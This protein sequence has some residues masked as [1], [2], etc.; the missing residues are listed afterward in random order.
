VTNIIVWDVT[1]Y[2]LVEVLTFQRNALLLSSGPKSKSCNQTS[3]EQAKSFVVIC[4]FACCDDFRPR[5][6]RQYILPKHQTSARLHGVTFGSSTFR[7]M[8]LLNLIYTSIVNCNIFF[9]GFE[10]E[11]EI[12]YNYR[13]TANQFVLDPSP[14][15]LTT[16]MFFNWTLAVIILTRGWGCRLQLLLALV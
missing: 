7:L 1:L 6:W 5:W 14:L 8:T 4:F 13:F 12:L 2:N 3:K 11:S 15:R 9:A 10:P 16:S